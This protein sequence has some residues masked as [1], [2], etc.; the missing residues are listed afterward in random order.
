ML[1]LN[2]L[3]GFGVGGENDPYWDSVKL[4]LSFNG[5]NNATTTVDSSKVPHTMTAHGNAKLTTTSPRFGEACTTLDGTG[6][7]WDT[8]DSAD[9]TLAGDFTVEFWFKTNSGGVIYACGQSDNAASPTTISFFAAVVSNKM[10]IGVYNTSGSVF[11]QDSAADVH[12]GNWHHF[13]GVRSGSTLK[14]YLDGVGT[15]GAT[16]TGTINN[17]TS[18][19]SVGRLGGYATGEWNGQIDEFRLTVGVARYTSNFTPSAVPFP[20]G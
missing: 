17:A 6:D 7:Y 20:H 4:L 2:Q 18:P 3:I 8:P 11:S 1:R 16:I 13:A 19:L 15:A 12:D 14:A 5:A 10:R 9:F